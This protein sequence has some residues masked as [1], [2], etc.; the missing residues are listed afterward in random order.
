MSSNPDPK[1]NNPLL[2]NKLITELKNNLFKDL[3]GLYVKMNISNR[4]LRIKQKSLK[5]GKY[6]Y[7]TFR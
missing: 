4:T 1:G 3:L 2:K 7:V 6:A 5:T